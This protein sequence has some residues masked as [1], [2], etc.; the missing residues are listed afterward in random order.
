MQSSLVNR[1]VNRSVRTASAFMLAMAGLAVPLSVGSATIG[2]PAPA[3]AQAKD[4]TDD[5]IVFKSGKTV[6][7]KITEE[8]ATNVKIKVSIGGIVAE[9]VY[10]KSEISSITRGEAGTHPAPK[11]DG[12]AMK[13]NPGAKADPVG[14]DVPK[15]YKMELTGSFGQDISQTPIRQAVRD[16]KTNNADYIIVVMDN[17]WSVR[18]GGMKEKLEDDDT[19]F[20]GFWRAEDMDPVLTEEIEREWTKKPKVVFWVKKAMGG[21]AFLPLSCPTLY[22]HSEGKMGGIGHVEDTVKSGD[23]V[24]K[25]KL[26]GARLGHVRGMANKGGYDARIVLA[27]ARTEYILSYRMVGGR[28][29]FLERMPESPDEFLLTDDG[30]GSNED[31]DEQLARG[32]GNDNLTLKADLA[33]KLGISKGTV[34]TFDDLMFQMGLARNNVQIKGKADQIMKAWRDGLAGA[35]RQLPRLWE[36]FGEVA[37]KDP[38]GYPERT[39][40]RGRRKAIIAEMQTVEK[41]YEEALNPRQVGVPGWADLETIKKQIELDQLQDKDRK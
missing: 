33:L 26:V 5:V 1:L 7:G 32:E 40:A 3:M 2:M 24:V 23:Q 9:T 10:E 36:S 25:E 6:K 20:E 4:G 15:V 29:E 17:D 31:T 19:Q 11:G 37:V 16:A 38:G 8:T 18:R 35:R 34:D 14:N 12:V 21:A 30:Q 41:R 13:V 27:M 22:F 39:A 28:P